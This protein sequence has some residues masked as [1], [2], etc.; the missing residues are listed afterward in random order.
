MA[1][2][3]S[4]FETAFITDT[5]TVQPW[6]IA[7]VSTGRW[8]VPQVVT[9][10][11]PEFETSRVSTNL[12]LEAVGQFDVLGKFTLTVTL[13]GRIGRAEEA[14]SASV[15]VV[16][17]FAYVR[18][19]RVAGSLGADVRVVKETCL[20]ELPEN[21]TEGIPSLAASHAAPLCKKKLN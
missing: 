5:V 2:S 18:A 4:L 10:V 11:A 20:V 6:L 13:V 1:A 21:A 16:V 7:D 14:R 8:S 12:K 19:A 9:S 3:T 17:R 15:K